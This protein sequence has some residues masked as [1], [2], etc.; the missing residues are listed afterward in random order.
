MPSYR[1]TPAYKTGGWDGKI[2]LL[3]RKQCPA[4]LFRAIHRD[5]TAETG[6][7]FQV[8]YRRPTL[9]PFLP[10]FTI[11]DPQY[12]YQNDCVAAM[13]KVLPRG[14]GIMLSA[15]RSGKTATMAQAMSKIPYSCLFVV[16][17]LD[18]LDQTQKE[19][20]SW[21]KEPI[22]YIGNSKYQ[23]ERVTVATRQTL[24]S[25]LRDPKFMAWYRDVKVVVIDE[26][27]EQMNHS[28]FAVLEKI[29]PIAR[30]GLTATL[31]LKR[32]DIRMRAYSFAGPVIY[33][34]PIQEGI[35]RGVLTTGRCL[36]LLFE[37]LDIQ[38]DDYH[39]EYDAQILTHEV[40][41]RAIRA[42]ATKLVERGRY[43]A[44]LTERVKHVEDISLLMHAIPH[45]MAYGKID[46]LVR[47]QDR[48]S[49]ERGD[50]RLIIANRVYKKGITIKRLDATIDCAEMKA[51]NDA[52]QKYGRGI[53]LHPDKDELLYIDIGTDGKNRFHRAARSRAKALRELSVDVQ[54]VR[55]NTVA[56]ALAALDEFMPEDK[57][58]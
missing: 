9:E 36:Q 47:T 21:L 24:S 28:N 22:G 50:V 14:G 1:F 26:L 38:T 58:S 7:D 15:T 41:M 17:Q 45:R 20:A 42:L 25:H 51:H 11:E 46:K 5:I 37:P 32:K 35:K 53:G 31:Q 34:F 57:K 19:L 39:D 6:I 52:Q 49:F 55:V 3:S 29:K 23:P 27:H 40:K 54:T 33:R 48:Q 12:S 30:Y 10:G 44:I 56:Q 18:L 43:V 4:G 2:H 13:L 8:T 16:D